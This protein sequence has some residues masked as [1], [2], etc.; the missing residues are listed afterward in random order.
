MADIDDELWYGEIT[1]DTDWGGDESTGFLAVAGERVQAFIKSEL[2]GKVGKIHHDKVNGY[3]L[4]FA[5]QDEMDK[6][7][8]DPT[9]NDLVLG[10]LK[11]PSEY[12]VAINLESGSYNAIPLGSKGNYLVF[13]CDVV[14]NQ[15]Q[16]YVDN[17]NYTIKLTHNS[18]EYVLTGMIPYGKTISI[19]IDDYLTAEGTTSV[20]IHGSGQSTSAEGSTASTYEVVNLSLSNDQDIS[21]PY[22]LNADIVSDLIVTYKLFGSSNIKYVEWYLDGELYGT[23][24]LT[25]G[26]AEALTVNKYIPVTSLSHGV[27]NLQFR[28]YI[29]VNGDKFYTDTLY[30]EF[31]VV[32][33]PKAIDPMVAIKMDIPS[34]F[35]IISTP[36]L[37]DVVQYET[38]SLH[39]GV[40]NPL[41]LESIPVNIYIND[42]LQQTVNAPNNKELVYSFVSQTTDTLTIKFEVN[43]LER[44]IESTVNKTELDLHKITDNL[45]LDLSALGRSNSDADRD[46]WNYESHTT[47]LEGFNYSETSG[48]NN[49]RLVIGD[50]NSITNTCKP[51]YNNS[52]G[53]TIEFEYETSNVINDNAVIC[54]L[55]NSNGVGLL[56][57][58]SEASLRVGTASDQIVSTKFK[59]EVNI[60]IGFVIDTGINLAFLYKDGH[61][62]G[63]VKL[64]NNLLSVNKE[65]HFKGSSDASIKL[66]QVSI[67][68][69]KLSADQLLNNFILNRDTVE[70]MRYQY[71]RNDILDGSLLSVE[72]ISQHVP[73]MLLTGDINWLE[74][75]KDTDSQIG[76]DAEFIN[77]QMPEYKFLI[78]GGCLRI[79]G[80]SSAGY[81]KKNF[82]LYTK[83]K[84]FIAKVYDY[85]G[86]LVESLKLSF[87]PGAVPVNCWCLKAD[88]AESSGTHNTSIARLWN[89]VMY[90]VNDSS[91]GY[92]CRTNAQKAA[93]ENGYEYDVR[94]T[95][96]GFPIVVFARQNKDEQYTFI[97]KYNF[98]NDKS[99]ENVFGFCDIPGFDDSKMQCWEMT[100]NG[101]N[102][103]LF[104]T[105]EGWDDQALDADGNPKFDE[106]DIPIKNWASGFEARYPDDGNEADTTDL[107][108][109]A[110]W[111][112]GCD[113]N[114]FAS[115]WKD[116]I[117]PWKMA[118]YYV[119]IMRFG[120]VDQVVKNSMFTSED[121]IHWYFINYDNDTILG[122]KNTGALVYP[123]TITRETLDGTT[124][125]YAGHESRLWNSLEGNAEFMRYVSRV[126]TL[127][128]TAG[129]T[130]E[131]V[132]KMFNEEQAGAW[133]QRIYNKDAE[134]KYINPSTTIT[135][136][137]LEVNTLFMMQGDRT[138]H[139]TWW[140]A[141]RFKLMDGKFNNSNYVN[142][143]IMIKLNGSPGLSIDI[144]AGEYMY[145]GCESNQVEIQMG[146]ELDKGDRYTFYK[147]SAVEPSGKDFAVGDPI[148][149]YAPYAI[150]ELDL[151][152]VAKYLEEITL[153][154]RDAVLGTRLKRLIIS[155]LDGPSQKVN[156]IAGMSNAVNL[157][158]LDIR[159]LQIG[160]LDLTSQILLRTLLLSGSG[161]NNVVLADG[162]V[163]ERLQLSEH[164]ESV[165]FSNLPNLT[166]TN[167]EG[168]NT[169]HISRINISGCPELTNNYAYY[170]KW[171]N[172][173]QY[174]DELI[175]SGVNWD[176]VAPATLI[177]FKKVLDV[178][179]TLK[180]KGKVVITEPTIEQVEELQRIFGA[181]C[182]TNNAE[183]WVSAP[184]SVFIHGPE[185]FRSGDSQSYESTIFSENPGVVTW[186][187]ESGVEWVK[188]IVSNPD[189]TGTLT[190][191][192]DTESD[193]EIVIKAIHTPA[194]DKGGAYIRIRTFTIISKKVVYSTY[195][196]I[197]GNMTIQKDESF[198]L[199]LGPETKWRGDYTT[200]W[201]V[202]G[203]S[204]TNGNIELVDKTN[205][206]VKIKYVNMVIFD[207]CKLVAIVTNKNGSVVRVES[208]MTVTDDSVL[209]T[210]TSNPEVMKICYEQGWSEGDENVLF[211]AQAQKVTDIGTAFRGSTIKT[212]HELE[213]FKNIKSIPQYAFQNC[214]SLTEITLPINVQ[215]LDAFA[216]SYNSLTKVHIPFSVSSIHY[217]AF[218]AAPIEEFTVDA[219][220]VTFQ[221]IDGVL[222]D[223]IDKSLVKYPEG[224]LNESYT[225]YETITQ[226]GKQ[227]FRGTK[228]KELTISNNV[229]FHDEDAIVNNESLHTINLGRSYSVANLAKNI[230][231]NQSLKTINVSEEHQYLKSVDGVVY[232]R[233]KTTLVKYP[234]GR[235]EFVIDSVQ[236]I[237]EYACAKTGTIGSKYIIEMPDSIEVIGDHAFYANYKV[238]AIYFSEASRLSA[239]DTYAFQL[240]NSLT[241]IIFPSTLVTIK[242]YAFDSCYILGSITFMGKS[243]PI[244]ADA[245]QSTITT[246]FGAVT[247]GSNSFTGKNVSASKRIVSVPADSDGYED[248]EW[249]FSIFNTDRN[250]FTLS[251]SL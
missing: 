243:A 51:L 45:I 244:L 200:D 46:S 56:L 250:G 129:L 60:R 1:R 28:A 192:E 246:A 187:I 76:V 229:V 136:A 156:F 104:Q 19:N 78:L 135:D 112:I 50:G 33:D 195:G 145:Y 127:L 95:V 208:T 217:T 63:A 133:C 238:T 182:F 157:E 30:R 67:Y 167:I 58:A 201:I 54:D 62:C 212:F 220:N 20:S 26:T 143:N 115:E 41:N 12:S 231:N 100:E 151:S 89:T 175:L 178:E 59:S 144:V 206:S 111:L 232:D 234:E 117:D 122:L 22:D 225:T 110:E 161:L 165:K 83:R 137:G 3:Y 90:N 174:G 233:S 70:E 171:V 219:G 8:A 170:Y 152:K 68:E 189:N 91:E 4:F 7:L 194:N 249:I 16:S 88:Y 190:T 31:I 108:A 97:G 128:Y 55:R 39:Y 116:H 184:E 138:A 251:K 183:L 216:L 147:P 85:L 241:E 98:N 21:I 87:K 121:G 176:N 18:T 40:Y 214:Y 199:V 15:G 74:T 47:K 193:H 202:E 102:Y 106:D 93:L 34:E 48:W 224:R 77:E 188:S 32:A 75:Q 57:T 236:K 154:V 218:M 5:N 191:I 94:T 43:G 71:E 160:S 159:G 92:V 123:P 49:N 180:L 99:T 181:D 79:Q 142:Q 109:F 177:E 204:F 163:I 73:V 222:I 226:L 25:G 235:S 101:N 120:A 245:T 141:K 36:R 198:K 210:S 158:Y 113:A 223:T 185:E 119:Y 23:D 29:T 203:D 118:A 82:R 227:C 72:K 17:V 140:L 24:T 169:Q 10:K 150:E 124:Y 239:L 240:A 168:F 173:V 13:N 146:V 166:L 66:K 130:Y 105:T 114:K 196:S 148:Y 230:S 131:N 209:M 228:L 247:G 207:L 6:Y 2:N 107:K 80:T 53:K 139:R 61:V 86:R 215:S 125:A 237:G 37:Y 205:D 42:K 14:N 65:L 213:E 132:I 211:K 197:E 44:S 134:Y 172:E 69:G 52:R 64:G 35:G 155:S 248:D 84:S 103:A 221:A 126:D 38:Y 162:C 242:S 164:T 179:A 27:H 149:I 186:E 96:D 153:T 11:A 81:P 9:L